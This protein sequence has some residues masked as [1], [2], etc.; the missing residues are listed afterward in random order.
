MVAVLQPA[1]LDLRPMTHAALDA[2]MRIEREAYAFPWT[3]GNFADSIDAGY[4]AWLLCQDAEVIGYVV[5]MMA[6]DEA[7]V[8]NFT[9]APAR[10]GEGLG[11]WF[12]GE[13]VR[14][15]REHGAHRLFLEVRPSNARALRLYDRAGLRRVGVRK[16]YYPDHAGRRE[17][18]IVMQT[19]L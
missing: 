9:V 7:H 1:A 17:D 19:E 11:A 12:F 16:G 10:Q 8:L 3:I 14:I 5:F 15:A 2:V 13:V 18:A 4:S 6:L